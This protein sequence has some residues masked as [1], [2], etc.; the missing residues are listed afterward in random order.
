V[1][2]PDPAASADRSPGWLSP[3]GDFA[4]RVGRGTAAGVATFGY[5]ASLL[6]QSIYWL[7][8]GRRERQAV[9]AAPVFAEM[10]EVGVRAI[11]IVGVLSFTVGTMLAI[12][13][14]YALE[15]FGAQEQVVLGVALS[16]TREFGPLI[17]GILMA[18]R[19]GTALSARLATMTLRQEVD[20]LE[21]IGVNPV[22]FL[23][24]PALV[25]MVIMLPA[26]TIWSDIAAFIGAGLYVGIELGISPEVFVD[27]VAS[28]LTT[29]DILHGLE[30]SAV[31]AVLIAIVGAVDGSSV[32]GGAEGVGRVTTRSVVH[33]ITAIILVDM[34]FGFAATR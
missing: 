6:L 8:F 24:V 16:V 12:Q 19:S 17:A 15:P 13:G 11:P 22:R 3:L 7:V 10:M 27:R 31:F 33:S 14:I 28:L 23:V 26:I 34:V 30:K 20:A 25:A 32:E 21:V 2:A 18:G 29:A 4:E 9:R 5:G 1:T